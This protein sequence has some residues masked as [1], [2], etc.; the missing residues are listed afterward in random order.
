MTTPLY[1]CV[2]ADVEEEGPIED[3]ARR[4][5]GRIVQGGASYSVPCPPSVGS[6]Q[7]ML[8][9]DGRPLSAR[10]ELL[11]GPN[12]V[13][14]RMEV[15]TEE[16]LQRPFFVVVDT[17]GGGNL[18]RIENTATVEYPLMARVEPFLVREESEWDGDA[19]I[20]W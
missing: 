12:N 5:K 18:I 15:Y 11:Q 3:F 9:T 8:H 10:I 16:G 20:R 17:P 6:L 13:K 14:Q 19:G 1:A 4:T 2:N 7:L